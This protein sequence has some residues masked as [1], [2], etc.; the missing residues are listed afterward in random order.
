WLGT[1]FGLLRFDGVRAIPWPPPGQHL[2][3]SRIFS[4]LAARDGTLW[5]G[6]S[7]GLASWKDGK[8]TQYPALAWTRDS[9]RDPRGSRRHSMGRRV[10][11]FTPW[12]ALH[13]S[14]R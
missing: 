1:E 4:L 11:V 12:E 7:K 8:L 10:G 6:S 5:I 14:E 2:P 9:R 3:S 13:D